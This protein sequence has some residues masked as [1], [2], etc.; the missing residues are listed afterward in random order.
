MLI[1]L[2]TIE[3]ITIINHQNQYTT[4]FIELR[5][6]LIILVSKKELVLAENQ[7][8]LLGLKEALIEI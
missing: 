1:P 8:S 7:R 3:L 6:K 4:L 2:L 5:R